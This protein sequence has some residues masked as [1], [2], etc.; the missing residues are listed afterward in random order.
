MKYEIMKELSDEYSIEKMAKHLKVSRQ[1]YYNWQR[2]KTY[3]VSSQELKLREAIV[4]V[5]NKSRQSYGAKRVSNELKIQGYAC[6]KFKTKRIM[7]ILNLSPK[8]SKKYKV[9][10]DSNHK[11]E[12]APNILDRDFTATAPNKKWVSDITYIYTGEGWLYLCVIIDLYSRLIV[13]WSVSDRMKKDLVLDTLKKAYKARN[14][15]SGLIFHS[16]RGSQYC[17]H[18]VSNFLNE[19]EIVQSMS[20]KG[21]CWDNAVSESFFHTLKI[22]YLYGINIET[23]KLARLMIFDYIETFYNKNR[24]HSYLDYLTPDKFEQLYLRDI[25]MCA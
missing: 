7:N 15:E 20:R 14:P 3:N 12:V 1:A 16:D 2:G 19:N 5:F 11:F 13:G 23:R 21:N 22:E 4:K 6:G 24:Q 18:E 10:T 17:A 25:M 8:A 9:T